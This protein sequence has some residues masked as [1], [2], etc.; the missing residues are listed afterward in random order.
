ML[1]SAKTFILLAALSGVL[2]F[3]GEAVAGRQG[4]Y[5]ALGFALLFN[6][7]AY[8]FS[9]RIA[10]AAARG[11]PVTEAEAPD[12]YG[13]V[14]NLSQRAGQPMPRLYISP[15]PQLNA[16]ATGRNPQHAAVCV[17]QGLYEALDREELE[18]VLA[19]ELQHVYNRDVLVGTVAATLA[20]AVTFLARMAMW[21]ALFGAGGGRDR[22]GAGGALGGLLMVFLAPIAAFLIQAA[23]S[24]SRE[25]LADRSG[26]ELCHNPLALARAL[27]KIEQANTSTS[28]WRRGATPA[29]TN[30]AFAHLYFS[31]PFG[32]KVLSKLF[33][34][35][36][37]TEERIEALEE[38]ARGMGQLGPGQHI[39]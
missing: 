37:P 34:T 10:I 3:A 30:P 26:A 12:L 6:G 4:L 32:G 23:V 29:E 18:G 31:A 36:P 5:F 28:M 21:G 7:V 22:D 19:H 17:N 25:S 15:S 20:A 38:M 9:D 24:R 35:H 13:I 2:L 16:F 39:H 33:S 11:K 8:F 27:R 14:R 1:K